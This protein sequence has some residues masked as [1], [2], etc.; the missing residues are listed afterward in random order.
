[1]TREEIEL[2]FNSFFYFPTDDRRHVTSV[3]CMLF[4]EHIAENVSEE[5]KML[6]EALE[7]AEMDINVM[8]MALHKKDEHFAWQALERIRQA[9]RGE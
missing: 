7:R 3:S 4:A 9:L 6:R 1:M 5:N 2:R 8:Y